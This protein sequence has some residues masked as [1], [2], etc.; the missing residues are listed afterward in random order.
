M[1]RLSCP[2]LVKAIDEYEADK[3]I[4]YIN[5]LLVGN[6]SLTES[7]KRV[8]SR[9]KEVKSLTISAEDQSRLVEMHTLKGADS[10][11]SSGIIGVSQNKTN[12]IKCIHAHVADY[13]IAGGT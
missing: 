10:F 9:W 12:D 13:L 5:N 11:M 1:V 4:E 3:G 6:N 2:L 8:N 7:F